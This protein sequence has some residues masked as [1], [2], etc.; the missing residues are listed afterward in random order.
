VF[1]WGIWDLVIAALAF[2]AGYSL[3]SGNTY[4][5]VVG[6]AWAVVVIIQSFLILSYAPWFGSA[7]IALAV[8]VV[9]A[10]SATDDYRAEC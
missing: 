1:W 3:L 10:L 7:A 8:L 4:G 2:F 6:Y 5:R 9:Y